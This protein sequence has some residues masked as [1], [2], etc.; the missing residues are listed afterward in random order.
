MYVHTYLPVM[1][2]TNLYTSHSHALSMPAH[3]TTHMYIPI[4]T[5][6]HMPEPYVHRHNTYRHMHMD[7]CTYVYTS[8]GAYL[9][10]MP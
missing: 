3:L 8:L 6:T 10:S 4:Y 7:Q 5:R 2:P 1:Y 9:C